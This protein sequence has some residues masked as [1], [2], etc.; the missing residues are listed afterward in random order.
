MKMNFKELAP[1]G[2]GEPGSPMTKEERVVVIVGFLAML[3]LVRQG[4]INAVQE[5]EEIILQRIS[6][7]TP[8]ES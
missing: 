4:I 2:R 6:E 3:E 1:P 7:T 8:S 5:N